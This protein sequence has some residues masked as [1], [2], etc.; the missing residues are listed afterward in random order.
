MNCL[1]SFQN[2][3][4]FK[5][6]VVQLTVENI[7]SRVNTPQKPSSRL[8]RSSCY[9]SHFAV[10]AG[11]TVLS[12]KHL[13]QFKTTARIVGLRSD[14]VKRVLRTMQHGLNFKN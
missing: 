1:A 9:L 10:R 5:T 12:A 8:S 14:S 2:C 13:H 7:P 11:S 4:G 3:A 6:V